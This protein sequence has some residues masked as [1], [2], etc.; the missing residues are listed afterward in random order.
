[1]SIDIEKLRE[2]LKQECY[3]AFFGGGYGGA[4]IEAGDVERASPE[5]LI[6]MAERNGI[7]LMKYKI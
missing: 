1:M 5:D 2:T 3:G 7:D 4:L 6:E